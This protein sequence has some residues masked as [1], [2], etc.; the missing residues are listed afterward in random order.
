[1]P[2]ILF[3]LLLLAGEVALANAGKTYHVSVS[4][5]NSA[6]GS[7]ASPWRSIQHAADSVSPGDTVLVHAGSYRDRVFFR[8]SGTAEAPILFSAA[9]GEAVTVR[10]LELAPG[11]GYLNFANLN[12]EGFKNWGVSLEGDNHHVT[13]RGLTGMSLASDIL[14]AEEIAQ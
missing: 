3:S 9:P 1:M 11:T 6:A 13:L 10:A 8:K 2:A 14:S 7:E 4:G 12:V 5:N